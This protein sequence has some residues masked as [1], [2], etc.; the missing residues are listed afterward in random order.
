MLK[1]K[2]A[3]AIM[4]LPGLHRLSFT[5]RLLLFFLLFSPVLRYVRFNSIDWME[6]EIS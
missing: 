6:E 4:R 5:D 3:L 2:H 1:V